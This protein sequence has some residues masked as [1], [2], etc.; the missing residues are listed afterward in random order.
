[1]K[2]EIAISAILLSL[3]IGGLSLLARPSIFAAQSSDREPPKK[4]EFGSSLKRLKWDPDKQAAIESNQDNQKGSREIGPG[5]VIKVETNLVVLDL[6]VTD[7]TRL[8]ALTGLSKDDFVVTEDA[9]TQQISMFSVGAD[10]S[11]WS[12]TRKINI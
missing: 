11:L 1:M 8:R 4:E 7:Q 3:L 5:D 2:R 6:F 12:A 10:P 9:V